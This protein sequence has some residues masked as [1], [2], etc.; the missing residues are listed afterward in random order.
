MLGDSRPD[1]R[2]LRVVVAGGGIAG[3]ETIVALRGL[4]GG[5]VDLTLVE[6]RE[7]LTIRA[8]EIFEPFGVGH[9]R[10]YP[11]AE[12]AAD[13]DVRLHRDAVAHVDRYERHLRLQSG[14]EL[15]YDALVLAV[16]AFP[17][18]A[19]EHGI[20]L[21]RPDEPDGFAEVLA[22]LRGGLARTVAVVVPPRQAWSLPAYELALMIAAYAKPD[23]L[24]LVTPE[25]RPLEVFGPPAADLVRTE[26][27]KAGVQVLTGVEAEVPYPTVVELGRGA[28]LQ[29]DRVVHLPVL[30]GPITPGVLCDDGGFVIVDDAFRAH[31]AA[32]V[33]AVGD[34]TAG[35]YK[36]GGL[37]SQQAD[38][39]ADLIAAEAGSERATRPYRPVMRGLLR[40]MDGPR[41]LRAEP[42][43]GAIS[44][45]VSGQCLWWPPSKV[46]ARW[47]TPWL[48]ARDLEG[49]PVTAPRRL[50]T[51]G[52]TRTGAP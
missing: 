30:S 9:P 12:L 35:A 45:E 42:P 39:V 31:D 36:Q 28:R 10:R 34:G 14:D 24:T 7:E 46:A 19:Y 20:C 11:L 21:D 32:N 48:A 40:T 38:V 3:L 8:L 29:C 1:R 27:E 2:R 52:I 49:R 15:D 17:Y 23:R 26:L 51:G 37:A 16:G 47:L 50:P 4:V 6:P 22:D 44:A 33:F 13:L 18:P 5:G 25:V 41:Y 43:G